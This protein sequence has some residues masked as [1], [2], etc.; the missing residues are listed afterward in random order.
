M[1]AEKKTAKENL[2]ACDILFLM[3]RRKRCGTVDW[4]NKDNKVFYKNDFVK[5]GLFKKQKGITTDTK[6]KINSIYR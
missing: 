3:K 4:M 5:N 1:N 2:E 6:L